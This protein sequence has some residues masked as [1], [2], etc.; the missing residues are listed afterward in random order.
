[1]SLSMTHIIVAGHSLRQEDDTKTN[2]SKFSNWPICVSLLAEHS[3]SK[4]NLMK[5]WT[6]MKKMRLPHCHWLVKLAVIARITF[7]RSQ[8]SLLSHSLSV[9]IQNGNEN[10]WK[11]CTR[12]DEAIVVWW[13]WN[14]FHVC[15]SILRI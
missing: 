7:L 2:F 8:I 12:C 1:M 15:V 10:I 4:K 5:I 9:I 6:E 13:P 11:L 3:S 14:W